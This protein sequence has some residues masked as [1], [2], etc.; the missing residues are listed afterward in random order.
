MPQVRRDTR[1]PASTPASARPT[2]HPVRSRPGGGPKP[3]PADRYESQGAAT[4][5][6][7]LSVG[8][9]GELSVNGKKG[10]EALVEVA[11]LIETGAAPFR[12]M[13][14]ALQEKVFT[15]LASALS[16]DGQTGKPT[17]AKLLTRSAAATGLLSLA[18]AGS[19]E[20]RAR[21]LA[22]YVDAMGKE[23]HF[24]FRMSM[25]VNL[26]ASRLSLVGEAGVKAKQIREELLPSRPPY[27][28]W[29][30]N[31]KD[32]LEVR[33]YVMD[34][35]WRAELSAHKGR[36]FTIVRQSPDEVVLEMQL[37]DP[38]GANPPVRA[39]VTMAKTHEDVFRDMNDPQVH[40]VVYS[41]H[42]QL[43][44]VAEASLA[45]A[46]KEMKGTKLVQMFSCRGKQTAGEILER[47]PRAHLTATAS[48]SYAD[49]DKD[50]LKT[51]FET[52]ARRGDYAYL[53]RSLSSGDM[54]QPRSNY[55]LPHDVRMLASRDTDNDG[56]K[57]LTPLGADRF[58]DPASAFER[59]GKVDLKARANGKAPQEISGE[60]LDHALS[61]ANT[62]FFYFAEE[63]R[64]APLSVAKSDKFL[65]AGWFRSESDE[66]VRIEPV[67]K[68]G[69][70]YYQVA[71]NSRYADQSR[72]A[73]TAMVLYEL[74]R[75]LSGEDHGGFTEADKLRGLM[76]VGNY[77]DLMVP[78]LDES[79]A[80]L[81]GFAQKYGF[82]KVSYD[83]MFKAGQRDGHDGVATQKAIDYLRRQ[84]VRAPA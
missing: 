63:N 64:A 7:K 19:S 60:K 71:V 25:M 76:L 58:F 22:T 10:K 82:T 67:K 12:S 8:R 54:I 18:A 43:G 65:T 39:R 66:P 3:K 69:K 16:A 45:A 37:V 2:S 36:G 56:L 78:Y 77:V 83:V 81:A 35:F 70:T 48:S 13:P 72:E 27:E 49:D 62:A 17:A 31:G 33:H 11:R 52:I 55:V 42:A 74:Q 4:R 68:D 59:G 5:E 1:S 41:G 28:E 23:R 75:H 47:F 80:V 40:M 38:T 57:D 73:L 50:V 84:G 29:F 24:P 79:E 14:R 26:E 21:T 9:G 20:L 32:V 51:T 15:H 34:D 44:G 30:K 6:P 53:Y 61:Y 46:P